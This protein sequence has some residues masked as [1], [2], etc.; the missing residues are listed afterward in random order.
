MSE[1]P[2]IGRFAETCGYRTNYHDHGTG[3]AMLVLHGSGAG[4]C[5]WANWR[6]F[7]PAMQDRFRVIAPDLVGFG[8]TET[9]ADFE[10]RFMDSWV[11]QIIALLDALGIE[12]AH[13]VGNSFGGSLAL[14]LAWKHPGRFDRLVLMGPGGWPAK[15]NANLE[16]LWDFK[17][18]AEHMKAAMSV[19][20][21]D[22][23]LVTDELIAMRLK[24]CSR[25]GA[26]DHFHKLFPAPRQR[27]LDAQTLPIHALQGITHP[28][29][30]VHGRDDVVVEPQVS[31]NLH[32]HLPNSEL[33]TIAKCGHWTMIE[34]GPRFRQLVG[35]HCAG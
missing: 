9:P 1:N 5:A 13:V 4:V 3:P 23:S 27:W 29:L 18:T 8:Y 14:W 15:V 35:D 31:W 22:K 16:L 24:A 2:E 21:W 20:A 7:I 32:Q 12:K 33:H 28:T 26:L 11:E 25:P 17:P 10:F 6:T 30:L 19:M 34:H